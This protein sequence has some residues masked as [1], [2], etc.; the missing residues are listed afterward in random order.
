LKR[1]TLNFLLDL[2]SPGIKS[3][4]A[5][6]LEKWSRILAES[7]M[8]CLP[9]FELNGEKK[10][11]EDT[12]VP[13]ERVIDGGANQG[14]WS[15]TLIRARP[16]LKDI[17]LIEPNEQLSQALQ[18]RFQDESKVTIK[19]FA[20][21]Y[22]RDRLPFVLRSKTDTHAHL[23]FSCPTTENGERT[24]LTQT[25]DGLMKELKWPSI[26]LLKLDLEGFDHYAL[27]GGRQ[28]LAEGKISLI[29]FEVTRAWEQSGCSPCA[30]FRFLDQ[31]GFD[32]YYI[33]PGGLK[34]IKISETPHFSIYSNF[35]ACL[36]ERKLPVS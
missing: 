16:E 11:I 29:Q 32:L 20:L 13:L 30:T 1:K 15:A 8:C 22:R 12:K 21:D 36:R 28:T 25:I 18:T 5:N 33:H 23:N 7:S 26:D 27:L 19:C 17:V 31:L 2:L 9:E 35:C 10:F 34:K 4:G 14:D 6:L 24:V 3:K